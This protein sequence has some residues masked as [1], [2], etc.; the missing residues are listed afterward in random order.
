M[1]AGRAGGGPGRGAR[2]PTPL[3]RVAAGMRMVRVAEILASTRE[4]PLG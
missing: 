4:E 2:P 1:R 3:S